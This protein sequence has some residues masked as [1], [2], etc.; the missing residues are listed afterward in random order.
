MKVTKAKERFKTK[1]NDQEHPPLAGL[2][3]SSQP[4]RG[5]SAGGSELTGL[6]KTS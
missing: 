2:G 3:I 1:K 6:K 5:H 4:S